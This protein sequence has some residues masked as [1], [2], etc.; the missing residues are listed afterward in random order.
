M[1][2]PRLN[3]L[4]TPEIWELLEAEVEALGGVRGAQR[5]VVLKALW[6][7]LEQM[8]DERMVRDAEDET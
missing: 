7:G 4:L 1:R 6:L 8:R 2:K 5:I 3:T